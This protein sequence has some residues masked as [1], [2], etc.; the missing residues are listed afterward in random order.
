MYLA[1]IWPSWSEG[2]TDEGVGQADGLGGDGSAEA[3]PIGRYDGRLADET[4]DRV[5]KLGGVVVALLVLAGHVGD[6]VRAH[7]GQL[8]LQEG[9]GRRLVTAVAPQSSAS[10]ADS[11]DGRT[12]GGGTGEGTLSLWR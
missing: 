2:R 8:P 3:P 4:I 10:P 1:R 6:V 7:S 12:A 5:D 9:G 11:P